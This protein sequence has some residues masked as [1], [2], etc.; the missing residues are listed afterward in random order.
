MT[1]GPFLARPE[2]Q[3]LL[4]GRTRK[5][6]IPVEG[7]D[8]TTLDGLICV[9]G[10]CLTTG[11]LGLL[12]VVVGTVKYFQFHIAHAANAP[13]P[14]IDSIW[15][16][17]VLIGFIGPFSVFCLRLSYI[18]VRDYSYR[19]AIERRGILLLGTLIS[20]TVEGR[21]SYDYSLSPSPGI[22]VEG[23]LW[24]DHDDLRGRSTPKPG[25]PV[26]VYYLDPKRHRML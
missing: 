21:V 13:A 4:D 25:T 15:G 20:C 14:E 5:Y 10:A 22:T 18:C 8:A 24:T 6:A 23:S 3:D 19:A 1:Q 2:N 11:L 16:M 12:T 26:V 9:L 17:L 7:E